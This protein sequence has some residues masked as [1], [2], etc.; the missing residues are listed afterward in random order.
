MNRIS[1]YVSAFI[2]CGLLCCEKFSDP[3][4]NYCYAT[5]NAAQHELLVSPLGAEGIDTSQITELTNLII[6]DEYKRIDG[7]LILRNGKLVYENYFHGHS[8]DIL[9]NIFSAGKSITAILTGIAIDKGFI[10]S[11]NTPVTQL[12]PEYESF[13]NPDPRKDEITI[14]HL[15]NMTSGLQ[16]DDWYEQTEERMQQSSDWVKF[17]LDLPMVDEP[18]THGSYCT[19]SA[20]TLGRIIEHASGLSLQ[21]FANRYLFDPLKIY[22]Y[23]WHI[24]PDGKASGGGLFFLRPRDMAKIGLFMLNNGLQDGEQILSKDWVKHCSETSVKLSGP[25]DGYGYLWWKQAFASDIETYFADGNGGQQIFIIPSKQLVLVF[26][27][28]NQNTSLGLQ[29]FGMIKDYI[30]PA[31]K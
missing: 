4:P 19:G 14:G 11:V 21:E 18:G 16:C 24:M 5:P 10:E 17:T 2:C 6:R 15:L 30:L 27:G 22:Q 8:P 13:Q 1:L 31:I 3:D 7:L 9:H 20:V 28:G 23:K 25:F 26:T 29:N 12:L